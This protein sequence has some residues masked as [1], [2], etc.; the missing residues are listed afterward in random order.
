M[1]KT[2]TEDKLDKLITKKFN[3]NRVEIQFNNKSMVIEY[4]TPKKAVE[5]AVAYLFKV[6]EYFSFT[7]SVINVGS[8][9]YRTIDIKRYFAHAMLRSELWNIEKNLLLYGGTIKYGG[10]VYIE[11]GP[12][13]QFP[14][15]LLIKTKTAWKKDDFNNTFDSL[16]QSF[17]IKASPKI[18]KRLTDLIDEKI[19]LDN[20]I[21][22]EKKE[23]F[24][25]KRKQELELKIKAEKDK[26]AKLAEQE[27]KKEEEEKIKKM[28]TWRMKNRLYPIEDLSSIHWDKRWMDD[29][30]IMTDRIQA[31]KIDSVEDEEFLRDYCDQ[32]IDFILH[33]DVYVI[34]NDPD[35]KNL[36]MQRIHES[37]KMALLNLMEPE[38]QLGGDIELRLQ[39]LVEQLPKTPVSPIIRPKP[40]PI[41]TERES[42]EKTKEKDQKEVP[43]F[44]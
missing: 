36:M 20:K 30:D 34:K 32:I 4:L 16:N 2:E 21:K 3:F 9:K 1:G 5:Q 22:E 11:M 29:Y 28:K 35:I 40:V 38:Q 18:I 6:I 13:P 10:R 37:K 17:K 42:K 7:G 19:Q 43:L 8:E 14:G 26:L 25:E 12:S 33:L 41:E 39:E 15:R 44:D 23:E 31:V 27:R 24:L